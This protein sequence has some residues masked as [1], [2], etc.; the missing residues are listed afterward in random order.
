MDLVNNKDN[1]SSVK[2]SDEGRSLSDA[3]DDDVVDDDPMMT[4]TQA[5]ILEA[6]KGGNSLC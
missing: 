2:E 4:S 3:V 1:E 6:P 5:E